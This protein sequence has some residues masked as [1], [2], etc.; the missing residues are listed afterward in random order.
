MAALARGH[1][2]RV[3][4][5]IGRIDEARSALEAATEWHRRAG[6]GEQALLGECL[7]TA[8]DVLDGADDATPRLSVIRSKPAMRLTYQS[9]CSRSTWRGGAA[10]P[11]AGD[12]TAAMTLLDDADASMRACRI[13]SQNAI[14]ST[15]TP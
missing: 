11:T 1:L 15:P 6:G 2:G 9:R 5:A 10:A 7:L 4:R 13:S 3:L 8:I 14:V 12:S